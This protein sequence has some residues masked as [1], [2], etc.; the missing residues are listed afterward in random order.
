[1]DFIKNLSKNQKYILGVLA[2][3]LSIEIV[4]LSY[5]LVTQRRISELPPQEKQ[6]KVD[7]IKPKSA[8]SVIGPLSMEELASIEGWKT[9]INE[10][11][12]FSIQYPPDWHTV[13]YQIGDLG[14]PAA[15]ELWSPSATIS[16]QNGGSLSIRVNPYE[17]TL[18]EAREE[19]NPLEWGD[20]VFHGNQAARINISYMDR[21]NVAFIAVKHDGKIHIF[22]YSFS[23]ENEAFR[24]I[25]E[26]MLKT[27][28]FGDAPI[29]KFSLSK[30]ERVKSR[31]RTIARGLDLYFHDKGSYLKTAESLEILEEEGYGFVPNIPLLYPDSFYKYTSD[32]QTYEIA[33]SLEYKLDPQC[34]MEQELCIYRIKDGRVV[35]NKPIY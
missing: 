34:I 32:G 10:F 24:D 33:V 26:T 29:E 3:I 28:K 20:I 30:S 11:D 27:F 8:P 18:K 9:Y 22:S 4:V 16:G 15:I 19:I 14:I 7:S 35:S 5:S 21:T 31:A 23:K 17:G 1:M 13:T 12:G 2:T 25:A 6:E